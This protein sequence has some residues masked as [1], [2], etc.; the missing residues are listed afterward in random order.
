MPS[1]KGDPIRVIGGTYAGRKGWKHKQ[2]A[3]TECKV[4][5]I[6]EEV[7]DG[8]TVVK[9]EKHVLIDKKHYQPFIQAT[10]A[11]Q[12]VIEQ[13][14]K[15]QEKITELCKELVK[16][17]S[18]TPTEDLLLIVGHTWLLMW[19]KKQAQTHI[20]DRPDS[21]PPADNDAAAGNA[22]DID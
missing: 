10:T 15:I 5:L 2:K 12:L 18:L 13:K 3:E 21:P 1:I 9:P 4:H 22:N 19:Q 6:L 20:H 17:D 11:I 14:P 8:D 7:K 16:I